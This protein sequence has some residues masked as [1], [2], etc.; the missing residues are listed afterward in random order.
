MDEVLNIWK[1]ITHPIYLYDNSRLSA[2]FVVLTLFHLSVCFILLGVCASDY[3]CPIVVTLTDQRTRSHKGISAAILLAWCNSS[4]DLFSNLMS[5]NSANNAAALSIGEVLGACGVIICVVQ[6]AI[7]MVVKSAWINLKPYERH[8]IIVD[9]GFCAL[10]VSIIGYVCILNR[11]TIWD[12]VVMLLIYI[13][14]IISKV[15]LGTQQ[16]P[17]IEVSNVINT[18]NQTIQEVLGPY[19][20]V[21]DNGSQFLISDLDT[22]IK[23]SLLTSMDYNSLL[24]AL[25]TS[26][27]REDGDTISLETMGTRTSPFRPVTEPNGGIDTNIHSNFTHTAPPT[28]QPYFDNPEVVLSPTVP[29]RT[30]DIF[31]RREE[32]LKSS[33]LYMLAPQLINFR[34]KGKVSQAIT[35]CLTPFMILLRVTIPQY[36]KMVDRRSEGSEIF[37]KRSVLTMSI[38]HSILAPFWAVLLMMSFAERNMPIFVWLLAIVVSASL[39]LGIFNVYSEV[40]L[41]NRFS[42]NNNQSSCYARVEQISKLVSFL[43]NIAGVCSSILWISYLANTLIEIMVLYQKIIHISEAILGLTIFSW[44]NSVSDLMSNVA[45]AKLY[46]KLPNDDNTNLDTK[47]FSISLGACLGGVLLNTMIGIG[48]SGLVAMVPAKKW[49]IV[50]RDNG[51]DSKFLLSCAAIILQILFLLW[52]FLT[53]ARFLQSHM[54]TVGLAM[55][56]WW[57]AATLFNLIL[58]ISV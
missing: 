8:S 7:F 25:E 21:D 17:A 3:L 37:F 58:E 49:S 38:V 51:V 50:L 47:F 13:T 2:S 48:M 33:A 5:W 32:R 22:G 24:K 15:S 6:G 12:C 19:S 30:E 23:P 54:R 29:V 41:A 40:E 27:L 31:R 35:L 46:H 36:D 45:M 11:V 52:L 57:L 1:W 34:D 28:F 26:L 53:N 10:S 43:F 56:A 55:C 9:L 16:V 18:E 44:G 4:P 14:Y 20:D 42:L 39:L